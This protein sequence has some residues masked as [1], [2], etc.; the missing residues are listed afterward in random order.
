[1]RELAGLEIRQTPGRRPK[2]GAGPGQRDDFATALAAAVVALE[3]PRVS[4]VAPISL[5]APSEWDFGFELDRPGRPL[6]G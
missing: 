3:E 5:E 4:L 1:M 2:I 6:L